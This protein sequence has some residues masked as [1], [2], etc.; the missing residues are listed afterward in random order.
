[1]LAS[2]AKITAAVSLRTLHCSRSALGSESSYRAEEDLRV[3]PQ[4]TISQSK[5]ETRPTRIIVRVRC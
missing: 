5:I 3:K 4:I 1:M 2:L